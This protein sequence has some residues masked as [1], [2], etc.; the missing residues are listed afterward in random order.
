[1]TTLGSMKIYGDV[2]SGNCGKVRLVA[3]HLGLSYTWVPVDIMN[4]ESRTPD[5][6]AKFPQ[7]QVPAI[8]VGD[9]RES[10]LDKSTDFRKVW[11]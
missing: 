7:G 8:E 1:M 11:R 9:G 3:D 6:L 2:A 10:A 4:G 5:Y